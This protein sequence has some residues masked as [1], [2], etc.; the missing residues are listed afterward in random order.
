MKVFKEKAR[1]VNR[2]H[3]GENGEQSDGDRKIGAMFF[4]AGY[5]PPLH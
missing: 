4:N 1:K 2:S 5:T 3:G